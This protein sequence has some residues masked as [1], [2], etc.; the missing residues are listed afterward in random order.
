[1]RK[2]H[3]SVKNEEISNI[4]K[5]WLAHAKERMD[6]EKEKKGGKKSKGQVVQNNEEHEEPE[7]EVHN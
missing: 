5:I 4:I 1:M 7:P 6:R 2:A 3:E